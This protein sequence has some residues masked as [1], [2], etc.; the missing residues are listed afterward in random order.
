MAEGD[1]VFTNNAVYLS[2]GRVNLMALRQAIEEGQDI[3]DFNQVKFF[4]SWAFL[5]C[6]PRKRLLT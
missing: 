6:V 4:F 1:G 3:Q 2:K 5:L